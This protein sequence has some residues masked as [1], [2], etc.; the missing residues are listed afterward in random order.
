V[1]VV[2]RNK[3]FYKS[4][5]WLH[6]II[7]LKKDQPGFWERESAYHNNADP[8]R[9][10]RYDDAQ[11][12]SAEETRRFRERDNFD[13]YRRGRPKDVLIK[14]NLSHWKPKTQDLHGL[15]LKACT[16]DSADLEGV[17]FRAANL[18]LG[19]FFR[20]NLT[21]VD[22]TGADLEGA[23]F[24]GAILTNAKFVDV[25][26]AATKFCTSKHDGS[27][28]GA[29]DLRGMVLARGRGLLENQ[30]IYLREHGIE[31]HQ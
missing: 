19:K 27:I 23:D 8:F 16:F 14:A 26:L 4:L 2:T 13:A 12:T 25:A 9:E 17:D 18:T 10:E 21:N 11:V 6:R 7:L 1:R 30:E 15:Q 24:S 20:A 29:K 22:F 3:Y 28:R 31:N 5:K